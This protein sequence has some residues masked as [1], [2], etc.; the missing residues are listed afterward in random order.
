MTGRY[1][2]ITT[3]GLRRLDLKTDQP[4]DRS[5]GEAIVS[6]TAYVCGRAVSSI[7]GRARI[8]AMGQIEV[9]GCGDEL[10]ASVTPNRRTATRNGYHEHGKCQSGDRWRGWPIPRGSRC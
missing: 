1:S 10:E 2:R 9:A 3:S 4:R 5:L 8:A 6:F 7:A